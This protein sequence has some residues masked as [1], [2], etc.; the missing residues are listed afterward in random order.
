M[1]KTSAIPA[2]RRRFTKN[3]LQMSEK[4]RLLLK[5]AALTRNDRRNML[6]TG[7]FIGADPRREP[8]FSRSPSEALS[9][10][11]CICA[12]RLDSTC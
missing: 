5:L 7:Q 2:Q 8:A 1:S 12:S 9:N 4:I 11:A 3:D 6:A 10:S